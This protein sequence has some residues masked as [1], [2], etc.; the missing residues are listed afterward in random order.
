MSLEIQRWHRY[1]PSALRHDP[2]FSVDSD[3]WHTWCEIEE[4]LRRKAGF[5]GD[6]DYS[7]DQPL[8][9]APPR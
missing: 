5:L 9:H 8:A 2:A 1:L 7:F 6:R 3:L 4:D